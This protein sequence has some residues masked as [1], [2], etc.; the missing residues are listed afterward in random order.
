VE[1]PD[2]SGTPRAIS[3]IDAPYVVVFIYNPECDHCIEETPY[4]V[5]F[6]RE[7]KQRG[8]EVYAIA[9]DTGDA[10]WKTFIARNNMNWINVHDPSNRSFYGKYYVDN[11]PEIYVLNPQRIIIGKNLK[12]SQIAQVIEMDRQE[13]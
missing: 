11:T 6:Y 12:V 7:W 10:S 1:A 3:N 8:I 13:S 9:I 2:P 5:E 4:L